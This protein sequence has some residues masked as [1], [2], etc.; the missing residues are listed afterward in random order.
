MHPHLVYDMVRQEQERRLAEAALHRAN[1]RGRSA[2][3]PSD[4]TRRPPS[5]WSVPMLLSSAPST[6]VAR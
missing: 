5:R 6:L 4:A 3:H 1:T 2:R